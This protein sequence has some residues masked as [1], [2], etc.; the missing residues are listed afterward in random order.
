M[1]PIGAPTAITG[2]RPQYR[3]ADGEQVVG[4]VL[5]VIASGG[6]PAAVAVTAGVVGDDVV[7]GGVDGACGLGPGVTVL[8][9]Q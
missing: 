1:P 5:G 9:A 4:G 2:R 3:C 7:A 8:S 6:I